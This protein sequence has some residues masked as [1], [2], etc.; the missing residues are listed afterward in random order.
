[1]DID[2][3]TDGGCRPNPGPGAWACVVLNGDTV[4]KMAAADPDTTNNRMELLAVIMGLELLDEPSN[5]TIYSDSQWVVLCARGERSRKKNRDLWERFD[6]AAARHHQV[7]MA[8]LRG[9]AGNRWNELCH[10]L[11]T[12]LLPSSG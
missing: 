12:A 11:V 3:Y 9:H 10:E 7:R 5:V 1:V 4:H 6:V 2:I 8:W